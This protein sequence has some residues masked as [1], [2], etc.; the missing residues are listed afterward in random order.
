MGEELKVLLGDELFN[1]VIAKL[2][3]KKIAITNDGSWIPKSKFDE[4]SQEIKLLKEQLASNEAKNADVEKLLKSNTELDTKYKELNTKYLADLDA[5]NK[6]ISNITKKSLIS[7]ALKDNGAIYEDLLLSQ[8]NLDSVEIDGDSLKNFDVKHLQEK[9][10][11]MFEQRQTT[12][13]QTTSQSGSLGDMQAPGKAALIQQYNEA[14][15]K[16]DFVGM[17]NISTQIKNLK[18]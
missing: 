8:I 11:S 5:K 7:K 13:A 14:E 15:K 3:D 4:K 17:M 6:E 16:M 2:G 10:E 9:Y 12:G 1:Q 18:E